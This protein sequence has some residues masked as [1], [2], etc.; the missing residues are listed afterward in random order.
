[1]VATPAHLTLTVFVPHWITHA[2]H[3]TI[4]SLDLDERTYGTVHGVRPDLLRGSASTRL[5]PYPYAPRPH[6]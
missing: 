5:G 4:R 3:A 6:S 1:M 2:T